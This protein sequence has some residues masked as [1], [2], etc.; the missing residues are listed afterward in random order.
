MI[1]DTVNGPKQLRES[2]KIVESL[3]KL[4]DEVG[5]RSAKE[6]YFKINSC[7]YTGYPDRDEAEPD[8]DV[9]RNLESIKKHFI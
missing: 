9:I 7:L 2:D 8:I 1:I 6:M 5:N 4:R 3:I